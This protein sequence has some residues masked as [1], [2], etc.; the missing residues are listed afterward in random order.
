MRLRNLIPC[1]AK[2]PI[3]SSI[4]PYLTYCQLVWHFSKA[5]DSSKIDRLQERV[6]RAVYRTKSAS[7]QTLLKYQDYRRC[8]IV[9]CRI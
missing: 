7:Y 6:L 2:L 3:M 8:K 4:L 5:S 1:S 9:D